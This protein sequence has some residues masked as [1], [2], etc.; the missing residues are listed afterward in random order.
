MKFFYILYI[1]L[2]KLSKTIILYFFIQSP[3]ETQRLIL[4]IYQYGQKL[5]NN[6]IYKLQ[7][8]LTSVV[9]FDLSLSREILVLREGR[10]CV[11][12]FPVEAGVFRPPIVVLGLFVFVFRVGRDGP[13]IGFT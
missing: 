13:L 3:R 8:K 1:Y 5:T 12:V 10:F 11:D 7:K 4:Y 6:I 9:T 2:F